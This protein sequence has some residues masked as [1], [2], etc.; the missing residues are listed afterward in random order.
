MSK[1]G[2]TS[3][4]F[5]YVITD[6]AMNDAEL[7]DALIEADEGNT[8]SMMKAMNKL[9]GAE[10]KQKLYEHLRDEHGRVPIVGERS[11]TSEMTEIMSG[12]AVKNS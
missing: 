4:G 12:D 8:T 3:T 10:Q 6:E 11:L 5:E 2:T 9:L 7:L 1:V